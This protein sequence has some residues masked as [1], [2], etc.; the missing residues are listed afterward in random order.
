MPGRVTRSRSPRTSARATGSTGRSPTSPSDTRIRT[1]RTSGVRRSGPVRPVGSDRGRLVFRVIASSRAY[2]GASS[3]Q[4]E[5]S[6]TRS[7]SKARNGPYSR[8][9]EDSGTATLNDRTV[10]QAQVDRDGGSAAQLDLDRS[11]ERSLDV[12]HG[13]GS[14][15]WGSASPRFTIRTLWTHRAHAVPRLQL[16]APS[17]ADSVRSLHGNA[18]GVRRT[19]RRF[20]SA[21]KSPPTTNQMGTP[22]AA[23]R[24][25]IISPT[26]GIHRFVMR[27]KQV[28][29]RR[30][31][32]RGDETASGP[33]G[34]DCLEVGVDVVADRERHLV[35]G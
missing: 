10:I 9:A 35:G 6:S 8:G 3:P 31:S 32:C 29:A 19:R 17:P 30:A 24:T 18:S 5:G 26:P 23:N 21:D 22:S 1:K 14:G 27:S 7:A 20:Q 15:S 12:M 4:E 25:Q 2:V 34:I 28:G 11:G 33:Q 16:P 13:Q